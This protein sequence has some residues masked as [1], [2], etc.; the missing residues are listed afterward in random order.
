MLG[1]YYQHND[2]NVLIEIAPD[3]PEM[4]ISHPQAVW[5]DFFDAGNGE[6][7]NFVSYL[8]N[9]LLHFFQIIAFVQSLSWFLHI[10]NLAGYLTGHVAKFAATCFCR[11]NCNTW[12]VWDASYNKWSYVK[13]N[14]IL[15]IGFFFEFFLHSLEFSLD[16]PIY[17]LYGLSYCYSVV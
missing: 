2:K 17:H 6:G 7:K 14:L 5:I 1:H 11:L 15:D 13:H 9:I 12:R 3:Q 8:S 16:I 10:K 4:T